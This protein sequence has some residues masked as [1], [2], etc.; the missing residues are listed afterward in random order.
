MSTGG[1]RAL[2]GRMRVG[3]F[4]YGMEQKLTGIG[5]YTV[6]LTRALKA[7]EPGL[8]I[9]LLNP[10]PDS[11]LG[12]YREFETHSVPAL[13]KLPA[14]ASLGNWVLHRVALD[15]KLDILHD[16]CG[17]APFLVPTRAY[18]RVTTVHDAIPLAMPEVQ[19]LATRLV[20]R[21]LIPLARY[22]AD[23]VFTVSQ[24][25]ALDLA[26]YAGLPRHKLFVAPNAVVP[27]SPMTEA[28]VLGAL[29]RLGV[30]PPY[31]LTVGQWAARKNLPRLLEAFAALRREHPELS[32]AVVG[33]SSG[34][35]VHRGSQS[36][37]GV[38][39]TGF[40]SDSDL[41]ALYYGALAL[42]FPSLYEGFGIPAIEAMAHGTPVLAANASSLPEVVGD[43]GVLFD[44]RSVEAIVAAMRR[45]WQD[46]SLREELKR[47]GLERAKQYTWA[48]TASKTL[49]VYRSLLGGP[50]VR[51]AKARA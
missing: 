17:I 22:T 3:F 49:E 4:T 2:G 18:R 37:E 44:P 38:T 47:R 26:R 51:E 28:E 33:P 48:E 12:W 50:M 7:L 14:A 31:F 23:A 35:T 5:R 13:R 24:H 15:L 34:S 42:V 10:Y 39:L 32:L 20:F 46:G 8:E 27:P 21:T 45:I 40:V 25:A 19:P 6:E 29:E 11:G 1:D 41:D 16:P 9:V 43:A 36:F 30:Q